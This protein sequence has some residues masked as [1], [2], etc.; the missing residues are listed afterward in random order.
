[1]YIDFEKFNEN[2][3]VLDSVLLGVEY[4]GL[5]AK[6]DSI[7][8]LK[9]DNWHPKLKWII[10]KAMGRSVYSIVHNGKIINTGLTSKMANASKKL[11]QKVTKD[12][13]LKP[14]LWGEFFFDNGDHYY[15]GTETAFK[16]WQKIMNY[17]CHTTNVTGEENDLLS[18]QTHRDDDTKQLDRYTLLENSY[19]TAKI[20]LE[21]P[22]NG[23]IKS[24]KFPLSLP[25]EFVKWEKELIKD[26]EREE[27]K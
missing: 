6:Y 14:Q 2:S 21:T 3:Y 1:M 25:T 20:E 13:L 4:D 12:H 15:S 10:T 24:R 26:I 27:V 16:E 5:C 17:L 23:F 7:L 8:E 11:K 18:T 9:L 19:D 22:T